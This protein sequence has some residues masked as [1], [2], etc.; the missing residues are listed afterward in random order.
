M[1]HGKEM[2]QNNRNRERNDV[3]SGVDT[4][5]NW[6]EHPDNASNINKNDKMVPYLEHHFIYINYSK[7]VYYVGSGKVTNLP[8][9]VLE[10]IRYIVHY[11][12]GIYRGRSFQ[13]YGNRSPVRYVLLMYS[14]RDLRCIRIEMMNK[15]TNLGVYYEL[16]C[17]CTLQNYNNGYI[18][19]KYGKMFCETFISYIARTCSKTVGFVT[20]HG[21]VGV[22]EEGC[23]AMMFESE[24]TYPPDDA[25]GHEWVSEGAIHD[26]DTREERQKLI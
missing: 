2:H 23:M 22:D 24:N 26:M 20:S 13:I 16:P 11:E 6:V 17:D 12:K 18:E 19:K 21:D 1:V 25:L 8:Y 7:S 9:C 5:N 14:K 3:M 15:A 4:Y 10:F